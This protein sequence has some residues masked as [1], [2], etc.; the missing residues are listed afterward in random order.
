MTGI[1]R[2][3]LSRCLDLVGQKQ[4]KCTR[5]LRVYGWDNSAAMGGSFA[6]HIVDGKGQMKGRV[7]LGPDEIHRLGTFLFTDPL[8]DDTLL[9]G[10][11]RNWY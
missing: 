8:P 1:T 3:Y 5:N 7:M 4:S 2:Q 6:F 11:V 10:E 9:E